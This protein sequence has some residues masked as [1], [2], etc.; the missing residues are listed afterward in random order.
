MVRRRGVQGEG[1]PVSELAAFIKARREELGMTQAELGRKVGW[2]YG[3]AVAMLEKG[4][5]KFPFDSAL[6]FADAFQV[7]RHEFL[8]LVFGNLFPEFAD[9]VVFRPAPTMRRPAQAGD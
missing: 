8:E 2:S 4:K 7:P 6:L 9:Y 5:M 1:R 3:N